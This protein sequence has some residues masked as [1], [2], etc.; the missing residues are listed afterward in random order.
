MATC[1][2]AN[3]TKERIVKMFRLYHPTD[4]FWQF[5]CDDVEF[6]DGE[7]VHPLF[8]GIRAP[9]QCWKLKE[10]SVPEF[11]GKPKS[12]EPKKTQEKNISIKRKLALAKAALKEEE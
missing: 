7:C 2:A 9:R 3:D 6:A 5:T 4:K 8:I 12:E 1:K 10:Y 11:F